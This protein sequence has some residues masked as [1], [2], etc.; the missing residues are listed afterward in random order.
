MTDNERFFIFFDYLKKHNK[1][2]SQVQLADIIGTDKSGVSDL[3][4][5]RKK[6][7]LDHMRSMKKKYPELNLEWF[8]G[9]DN[10]MLLQ[11]EQSIATNQ[12]FVLKTDRRYD[13][14]DIPIYE[15]SAAASLT[16]VFNGHPN[17]LGH[18]KIPNMPKSDGALYVTGD[19]MYPLLKSGDI[20]IYKQINDLHDG[21]VYGEMHIISVVIDG[22][23]TT[24]IKFIQKSEKGDE[25]LRLVSQNSYHAPRDVHFSKVKAAALIKG[26][27]RINSMM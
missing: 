20:A 1:I 9:E 4:A 27:V 17:I 11:N 14:Q 7:S 10:E 26:S 23:L 19:S 5:G 24:V 13:S 18:L 2:D 6:I 8:I 25:W 16:T 12:E 15:L 21:I 3:K 22:D